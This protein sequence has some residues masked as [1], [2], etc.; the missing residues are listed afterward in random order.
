MI[1]VDRHESGRIPGTAETNS[2]SAEH[3]VERRP[4]RRPEPIFDAEK[5]AE[6][7]PTFSAIDAIAL[8]EALSQLETNLPNA[9]RVIQYRYQQEPLS[10]AET[11]AE[12]GLGVK[13]V[14]ALEQHALQFLRIRLS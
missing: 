10:L 3:P 1:D 14:T 4:N 2:T 11:A 13:A 12:M 5:F 6:A 8:K 9:F 7:S